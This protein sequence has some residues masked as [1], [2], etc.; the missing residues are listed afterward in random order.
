MYT[1]INQKPKVYIFNRDD[2]T[3][4]ALGLHTTLQTKTQ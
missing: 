2:G 1:E 3:Q 4:R